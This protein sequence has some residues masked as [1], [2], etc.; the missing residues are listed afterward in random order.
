[1]AHKYHGGHAHDGHTMAHGKRHDHHVSHKGH[2][3]FGESGG[4]HGGIHTKLVSS[5]MSKKMVT[6]KHVGSGKSMGHN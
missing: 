5:P 2:K 4:G 3:M 6:G 1:M